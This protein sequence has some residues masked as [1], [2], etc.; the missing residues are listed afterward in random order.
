MKKVYLYVIITAFCFGTLEISGKLAGNNLDAFQFT[1]W[2]FLIG[3]LCLV[4]IALQE[5]KGQPP[6][7]KKDFLH[8]IGGGILCVPVSMSVTQLGI[9]YCNASTAGVILGTNGMF[10]MIFAY[11]LLKESFTKQKATALAIALVGLVFLICPW[12]MQPGNTLLGT[13][14]VFFGSVTFGLYVAIG[15]LI[16]RNTGAITQACLCMFSGA[17]VLLLLL[18]VSGKPIISGVPENIG[19]V[20]YAG[21]VVTGGGYLFLFLAIKH[22]DAST[23]S[24]AFFLK[25]VIAPLLSVIILKDVLAWNSYLGILLVLISSFINLR[26]GRANVLPKAPAASEHQ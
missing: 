21:I 2:R 23:G 5:R 24:I 3:S 10:T 17:I 25:I 13:G 7:R 20:L 26:A 1:F 19:I 6:L 11:F 16:S 18:L 15:K 9:M 14:L 12:D 22:S 4:P 8:F